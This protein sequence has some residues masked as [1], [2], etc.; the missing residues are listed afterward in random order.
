MTFAKLR[1]AAVCVVGVVG[2][3]ACGSLNEQSPAAGISQMLKSRL[4]ARNGPPP[5]VAPVLTREAADAN[6]GAFMLL[7]RAGLGTQASMVTAGVNGSKITWMSADQVS[8]TLEN[9]II[10]ATRGFVQDMMAADI[11]QVVNALIASGGTAQRRV[12]YL[13]GLDQISTELLQCR[14]ASGGFENV[15]ALGKV[16]ETERFDEVCISETIQYTNIYWIN[17][18]GA[19][20]KSRQLVSPGVGYVE[21]V[22]P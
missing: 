16:V 15:E 5:P 1:L 9:G 18:D 21:L 3:S 6:P 13:D 8:V 22:R 14:I 17:D 2:L 4:T 7:S 10:V 19:I 12:E 20:T 11:T